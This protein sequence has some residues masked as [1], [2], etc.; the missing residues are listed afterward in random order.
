VIIHS[1]IHPQ[2]LTS[3]GIFSDRYFPYLYDYLEKHDRQILVLPTYHGFKYNYFTLFTRIRKSGTCFIVPEIYLKITDLLYTWCFPLRLLFGKIISVPFRTTDYAEI[4]RED[5]IKDKFEDGLEAIL[6]YRLTARLRCAGIRPEYCI[7]W[8]ENQAINRALALGLKRQFTGIHIAGAQIFLHYPNFLSLSPSESEIASSMVPDRLLETS[9]YQCT[10]ASMF[11]PDLACS[12]C[13]S[14]RYSQLFDKKGDL[15]PNASLP[16]GKTILLLA[17]FDLEETLELLS[18]I[19]GIMPHLGNGI[20]VLI[21]LHPDMKREAITR[22]YGRGE[23]PE[24]VSIVT[25]NLSDTMH[26][27]SI[28]I[29]KSSGSIVEA[30]AEGIPVIFLG[31]Q[32]KLNFNPLA[33]IDLPGITECYTEG[34]LEI[35]IKKY[36][37]ASSEE[38]DEF[39]VSGLYLRDLFFTEVNESTLSQFLDTY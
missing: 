23:W 11:A 37:A 19:Q 6:M 5:T 22:H 36:L 7:D 33:G 26:R 32:T 20:R 9:K 17:S 21:K 18:Q 27:A 15:D 31:N 2:S 10:M 3:T 24:N 4:L 12:S 1:Y 13:A 25:G 29:S 39:R 35:S 38:R 28:V 16:T 8:Y 34:E 30:A 14:L